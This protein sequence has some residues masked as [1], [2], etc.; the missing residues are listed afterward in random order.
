MRG[1]RAASLI[2]V[3]GPVAALAAEPASVEAPSFRVG[4]S[5]VFQENVQTGTSGFTQQRLVETI[6]RVSS[7]ELLMGIKLDGSPRAP[8]EHRIGLDLSQRLLVNGS[9]VVTSRP[10]AFPMKV[11]QSWTS[12][13]TDPR[14][15]GQR[16]SARVHR[17]YKVTGWEDVTVPAGT[18]HALKIEAKGTID[19]EIAVPAQTATA[20]VAGGGGSTV[21]AHAQAARKGVVHLTTFDTIYYAPEAKIYVKTVDEQYNASDVLVRRDTNEL[22]AFTPAKG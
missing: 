13:W 8:E 21:V 14:P 3:M 5:W 15:Q 1:V 4:D 20:G 17:T 10:F 6:D 2:W 12:E 9:E 22:A 18:F 11:G 7:D 16:V 19:D